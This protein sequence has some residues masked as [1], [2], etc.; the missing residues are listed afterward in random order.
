[1]VKF[2]TLT[3]KHKDPEEHADATWVEGGKGEKGTPKRKRVRLETV[4]KP[5][6][7]TKLHCVCGITKATEEEVFNHRTKRH[8]ETNSLWLQ[9]L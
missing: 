9:R 3:E 2:F 8:I 5:S 1:M 7:W 4:Q 6:S